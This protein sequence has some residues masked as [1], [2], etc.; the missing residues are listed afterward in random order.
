MVPRHGLAKDT[1]GKSPLEGV[2]YTF[3]MC[4]SL[5]GRGRTKLV[6][7]VKCE[8]QEQGSRTPK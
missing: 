4:L 5:T 1:L 7:S 6:F 8:A 3:Q 2:F